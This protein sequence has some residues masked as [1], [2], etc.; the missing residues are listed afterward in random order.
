MK[1]GIMGS[2]DIVSSMLMLFEKLDSYE[3]KAL[4]CRQASIARGKKLAEQYQIALLYT[5]MDEFLSDTSF[6]TVYIAVINNYHYDYAKKALLKGKHVICEKPFTA[7]YEQALELYQL[8]DENNCLLYE[9]SRSVLTDNYK[10]I[11]ENL[12][13]LGKIHLVSTSLCHYSRRY[14][15][16]LKGNVM[17][18]FDPKCNGGALYD[19]GIYCLHFIVGLFHEPAAVSYHSQKGYNGVDL[20]GVLTLTYEDLIANIV[21]SK[22]TNAP[23]YFT[24][25]GENGYLYSNSSVMFP[26]EVKLKLN[27]QEEEIIAFDSKEKIM[28]EWIHLEQIFRDKDKKACDKYMKDTLACIQIIN[29]AFKEEHYEN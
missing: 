6:D 17:P 19:F 23:S 18:V 14:E 8:A 24:I 7:A 1:I 13:R 21:L 22:N 25:Q 28:S 2:G 27:N 9:L 15:E 10:I 26:G 5:D 3:C 12:P 11:Q 16:Y 29:E 4:F 20:S